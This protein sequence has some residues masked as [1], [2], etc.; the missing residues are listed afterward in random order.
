MGSEKTEAT[1]PGMTREGFME[2]A[3]EGDGDNGKRQRGDT[4]QW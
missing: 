3:A 2:W 4:L 1:D